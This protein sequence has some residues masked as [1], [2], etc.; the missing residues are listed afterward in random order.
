MAIAGL[1]IAGL[2]TTAVAQTPP[3]TA[4]AAHPGP[5]HDHARPNRIEG[6]IA[7]LKAELK[8]TPAQEAQWN[9]VADAMRSNAAQRQQL[10]E[11]MRSRGNQ[12]VTA[13]E[14]LQFRERMSELQAQSAKSLATTFAV[15][16]TS[17]DDGQKKQADELLSPRRHHRL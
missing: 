9:T 1:P 10:F 15:L 13:V 6:R 2:A 8:I 3:S 4:G 16:Y 12:P 5:A 7:Y 11:Q 17:L 14:H